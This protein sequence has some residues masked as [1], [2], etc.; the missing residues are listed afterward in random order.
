MKKKRGNAKKEKD[1]DNK[2]RRKK[3]TKKVTETNKF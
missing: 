3:G 2:G 1:K